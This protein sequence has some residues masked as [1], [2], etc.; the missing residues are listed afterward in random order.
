MQRWI[1]KFGI[2]SVLAVALTAWLNAADRRRSPM[3]R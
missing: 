3:P 1:R 2:G